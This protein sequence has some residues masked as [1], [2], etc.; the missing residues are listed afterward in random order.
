[1]VPAPLGDQVRYA[2]TQGV[3]SSR[4]VGRHI[5]PGSAKLA[6]GLARER[7]LYADDPPPVLV[8]VFAKREVVRKITNTSARQAD[9]AHHRLHGGQAAAEQVTAGLVVGGHLAVD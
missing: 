7:I 5:A 1:V 2:K 6:K 9:A 4:V 8:D 3:A